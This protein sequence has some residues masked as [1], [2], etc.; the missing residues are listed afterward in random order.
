MTT[1]LRKT[2]ADAYHAAGHA[3]ASVIENLAIDNWHGSFHTIQITP[4]DREAC[5]FYLTQFDGTM[6]DPMGREEMLKLSAKHP[7]Y[8]VSARAEMVADAVEILCGP[9][10]QARH[11]GRPVDRIIDELS[12]CAND[13]KFV[14]GLAADFSDT[15][16]E[17]AE[18]IASIWARANELINRP[19]VWRAIEMVA[20]E[21][22]DGRMDVDRVATIV[23]EAMGGRLV[24]INPPGGAGATWKED[25]QEDEAA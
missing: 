15:D 5:G 18:I 2:L 21:L 16:A 19:D 24:E 17:H 11:F 4:T 25:W 12:H 3:V 7:G 10:A 6:G 1:K 20:V 9:L 23:D 13:R 14:E 22:L 8:E